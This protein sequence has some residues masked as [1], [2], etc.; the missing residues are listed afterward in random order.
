MLQT[1]AKMQTFFIFFFFCDMAI[2]GIKDFGE[3][4]KVVE[5]ESGSYDAFGFFFLLHF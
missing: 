2:P 5:F 1:T 4:V 3:R